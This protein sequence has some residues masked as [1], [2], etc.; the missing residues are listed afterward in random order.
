MLNSGRRQSNYNRGWWTEIT[1][2]NFCLVSGGQ[3]VLIE[4]FYICNRQWFTDR[5]DAI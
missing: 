1:F 5:R 3:T 4:I 2:G